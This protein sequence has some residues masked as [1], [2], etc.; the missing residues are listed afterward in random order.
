[1]SQ[2]AFGGT[3]GG[4]D[5]VVEIRNTTAAAIDISGWA[6]WGANMAGTASARATVPANT[7]LPAGQTYVFANS[8]GGFTAQ[9]DVLYGTGIANTGGA[10][11]R[12]ATGAVR[13]AFGSTVGPAAY[14]EGAGI[15]Q[16][17]TG[18]GGFARKRNGT[19]DTDDNAADFTGP[20]LPKPTKCGETCSGPVGP[21]PCPAGAGGIVPITSIQTLGPNAACNGTTVKVR[22]IVTGIDDLYGS[23]FDAIYKGD[24]GIWIQE[25][26]RDPAA[27]T[28]NALFVAG[29]R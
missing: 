4:N 13:D 9:A 29:I 6:L 11:L 5:E 28:S 12:D 1:M 24:S 2:V 27:T 26:T 21:Q 7:T 23:S 19:Q 15:A 3:G 14:R 20:L 22:G 8:A 17:S 25:P 18:D 16:P 10:Q